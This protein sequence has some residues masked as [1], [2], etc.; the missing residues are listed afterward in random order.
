M[1]EEYARSSTPRTPSTYDTNVAFTGP[2]MV[3]NDA[4]GNLV[5]YEP[6]KRIELVRN[7]NWDA[8]T[9]YRPAYLDRIGS[10]WATT[11]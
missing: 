7:P 6:G 10:R 11:T 3:K 1:P 2:Y 9:D 4:K 5:G 8:E